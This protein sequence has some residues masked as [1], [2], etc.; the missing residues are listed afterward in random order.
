MS[1][2]WWD[3]YKKVADE[4]FQNHKAHL[5]MSTDR[6]TAIDWKTPRHVKEVKS[7]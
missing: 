6:F 7:C 1:K 3:E 5:L 2:E 4:K